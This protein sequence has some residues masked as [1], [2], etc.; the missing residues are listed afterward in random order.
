MSTLHAELIRAY[1]ETEYRVHGTP[2]FVLRIGVA[3]P[4]LR[5]L[6]AQHG[7]TTSAFLTAWNPQ[8]RALD[9]KANAA[10]QAELAEEIA[11]LGL[12]HLPGVGQHP[13]NG[14]PAEDSF[15]VLG[16]ELD[17]A[18]AL[19]ARFEQYAIVWAGADGVPH[20]VFLR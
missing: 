10:R 20:L 7:V 19:G 15:L 14:W 11:R 12:V 3:S 6:T 1:L 18:K 13:S 8:S 5:A 9:P 17:A 2:G 16:L 4:E